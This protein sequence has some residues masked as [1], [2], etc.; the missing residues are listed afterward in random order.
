MPSNDPVWVCLLSQARAI[1]RGEAPP[2]DGGLLALPFNR[3]LPVWFDVCATLFLAQGD[4]MNDRLN[5][6]ALRQHFTSD[7]LSFSDDVDHAPNAAHGAVTPQHIARLA[8]ALGGRTELAA[9]IT[10]TLQAASVQDA[11]ILEALQSLAPGIAHANPGDRDAQL[12]MVQL[13]ISNA[14]RPRGELSRLVLRRVGAD[15][16]SEHGRLVRAPGAALIRLDDKFADGIKA[17]QKLLDRV[18]LPDAPSV[19]WSLRGLPERDPTTG[20]EAPKAP[21]VRELTGNSASAAIAYGA[22]YLLRRHLRDE[23]A[24]EQKALD[25]S[26]P[27]RI[28]VSAALHWPE[29]PGARQEAWPQLAPVGEIDHKLEVIARLPTRRKLQR[30][31]GAE[32]QYSNAP[33]SGCTTAKS[34]R[35]LI[36]EVANDAASALSEDERALYARLLGDDDVPDRDAPAYR[37]LL[38]R[39]AAAPP[40]RSTIGY[41]LRSYVR[42]AG[43][44]S[45]PFMLPQQLDQHF[46]NLELQFDSEQVGEADA[47]RHSKRK[48][49]S[50]LGQLLHGDEFGAVNAWVLVGGPFAGK[51]TLLAQWMMRTARE[52]LRRHRRGDG[53][54][55]V[56]IFVP[57]RNFSAVL[58]RQAGKADD[59]GAAL[60]EL[61]AQQAR[62]LP[63]LPTLLSDESLE[64]TMRVRLLIDGLNEVAAAS[65]GDRAHIVRRVCQWIADHPDRHLAP[66]FSV[67]EFEFGMNLRTDGASLLRPVQATLQPWDRD[68]IG[69]YVH[70]RSLQLEDR[71]RLL[72]AIDE[73]A[74]QSGDGRSF[75]DF[76]AVPGVLAGQCTLLKQAPGSPLP[77]RRGHLLMALLWSALEALE[78]RLPHEVIDDALVP[79]AVRDRF[80]RLKEMLKA[81]LASKDFSLPEEAG[82]LLDGLAAQA[83]AMQDRFAVDDASSKVPP[84]LLGPQDKAARERWLRYSTVLGLGQEFGGRWSFTHQQWLELFAALGLKP[85]APLD[86]VP[87]KL[88]PPDEASLLAHLSTAERKLQLPP[89][90]QRERL[91]FT[92]ELCSPAEV[93]RWIRRLINENLPLAAHVAIAHRARLE[94]DPWTRPHPLLQHLRRLLLL[95]SV[96]AGAAVRE[97]VL[98]SGID[99]AVGTVADGAEAELRKAWQSAWAAA[100][101]GAG[102]DVR[103]RIEAGLLLGELGDTLRYERVPGHPGL[104][105]REAH[106]IGTGDDVRRAMAS[107]VAARM[108]TFRIGDERRG[109]DNEKPEFDLALP[110]FAIAAYPVTVAEWKAFVEAGGYDSHESGWWKDQCPAAHA[111]LRRGQLTVYGGHGHI[112]TLWLKDFPPK[113][114]AQPMDGIVWWEAM[115][116]ARWAAPMYERPGNSWKLC[117]PT[118]VQWEAGVRG[119]RT[120]QN[121]TLSWPHPGGKAEPDA[122]CFNHSETRWGRPSPVGV[123]SRG[124]SAAGVADAA[125][126]VFEWCANQYERNYRPEAGIHAGGPQPHPADG[127]APRAARGGLHRLVAGDARASFRFHRP[128]DIH[129][130]TGVR[131]VRS[132]LSD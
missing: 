28:S 3:P 99:S 6:A 61:A 60:A 48:P 19:A 31:Y 111:W 35:E 17:A 42:H 55:E 120:A 4:P 123:F 8:A 40:P 47:H 25:V 52:A 110:G 84:N 130:G 9:N 11:L 26:E 22:L 41:L 69:R 132:W 94:P 77:Q 80:G 68:Q 124:Y 70:A 88:D 86:L 10:N 66:V 100:F 20:K 24:S 29:Q 108:Q 14:D 117:V 5:A 39:V 7:H 32:G 97:R 67:R 112:Q 115:A 27:Q 54:G 131:L 2:F 1:R 96:D 43:G 105:L 45:S 63:P 76:C 103:L 121:K 122:L 58:A 128:T 15:H 90:P 23:F 21:A 75:A 44:R 104:R 30:V 49:V 126:N 89:V 109:E 102:V 72:D 34:L 82:G 50:D 101:R 56:C 46:V 13:L 79:K 62:G 33:E 118:E 91:L 57:M 85:D 38:D 36:H 116:Y 18:L 65:L 129:N 107:G 81:M 51:T 125:G 59:I 78:S 119:P 71:D 64:P 114:A 73:S 74:A 12:D 93:K 87:P 83:R 106:W 53:W 16:S 37:S 113:N 98:A 92:A 127:D 95:R